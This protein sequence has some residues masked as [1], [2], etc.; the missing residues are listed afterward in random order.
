M[1]APPSASF[2][3]G[4]P[5]GTR[6]SLHPA[7]PRRGA[8]SFDSFE[9]RLKRERARPRSKTFGSRSEAFA[10]TS[11]VRRAGA[12]RRHGIRKG[13]PIRLAVPA[14]IHVLAQLGRETFLETWVDGFAM[15]YAK[16]DVEA[17]LAS[18]F[19]PSRMARELASSAYHVLVADS[20]DTL[21]GSAW[22]GPCSLPHDEVRAEHGELKRLY[23]RLSAQG[24]G[25]GRLLLERSLAWVEE[26]FAGPVWLGVWSGNTKA[27]KLYERHG[28]H[29]VGEYEYRVGATRDREFIFRRER[30]SPAGAAVASTS[31][32][33]LR[34][35]A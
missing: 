29:K 18:A 4:C 16:D 23:V 5:G 2:D 11:G 19:E 32:P 12:T 3:V 27:Q 25:L 10:T 31:S 21:L 26:A 1:R 7:R 30:G 15:G 9:P 35:R 24:L 14:D 33:S 22:S 6:F 13:V 28:F 17:H 8:T 34:L 20:G